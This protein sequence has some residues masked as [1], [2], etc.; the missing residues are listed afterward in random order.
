M[1]KAVYLFFKD[2]SKYDN[3]KNNVVISLVQGLSNEHTKCVE[4]WTPAEDWH[5]NLPTQRMFKEAEAEGIDMSA[6]NRYRKG[7]KRTEMTTE[8]FNN[9]FVIS[10]G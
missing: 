10:N 1:S 4:F 7:Q 9:L 8:E 2:T 5:C 6:W 3:F